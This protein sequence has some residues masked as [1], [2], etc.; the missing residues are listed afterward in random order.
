VQRRGVEQPEVIVRP[1]GAIDEAVPLHPLQGA[2]HHLA[3]RADRRGDR[4]VARAHG[5]RAA[6]ALGEVQEAGGDARLHR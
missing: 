1:A 5:Q 2:C 3:H 4:L 6:V